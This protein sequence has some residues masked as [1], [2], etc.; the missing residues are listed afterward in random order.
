MSLFVVSIHCNIIQ[1]VEPKTLH[2]FLNMFLTAAVPFFFCASGYLM[3]RSIPFNSEYKVADTAILKKKAWKQTKRVL[4]LYL[5]WFLLY[6]LLGLDYNAEIMPYI[7]KKT[8]NFFCWGG[9]SLW[10]LWSMTLS[11][12]LITY[13]LSM[14]GDCKKLLFISLCSFFAFRAYAHYGSVPIP[15]WWQKPLVFLWKGQYF[16]FFGIADSLLYL[17]MGIFICKSE[18]IHKQPV[19]TFWFLIALGFIIG[20]IDNGEVSIGNIPIAL[21]LFSLCLKW[22]TTWE[23]SICKKLRVM[24]IFIYVVHGM[25]IYFTYKYFHLEPV[26]RWVLI[27]MECILLGFVFYNLHKKIKIL[28][29]LV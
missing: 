22:N 6:T 11:I 16:N 18:W 24:S 15:N 4:Q 2:H 20:M 29:I 8:H 28:R 25:V 13:Y 26:L 23:D 10:Y 9:G 1:Q 19:R 12:P 7:L 3:T 21:G 17:S 27:L 5:I 14:G